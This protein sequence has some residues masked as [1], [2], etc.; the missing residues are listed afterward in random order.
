MLSSPLCLLLGHLALGSGDC[1]LVRLHPLPSHLTN[2]LKASFEVWDLGFVPLPHQTE[3]P[4]L[5][6]GISVSGTKGEG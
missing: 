4:M 3:Q 6:E 2:V 1:G 5:R